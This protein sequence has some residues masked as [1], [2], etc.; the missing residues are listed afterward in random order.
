MNNKRWLLI[1]SAI[2]LIILT[3]CTS[4]EKQMAVETVDAVSQ[5]TPEGDGWMITLTGVRSEDLYESDVDAWIEYNPDMLKELSYE[6]KGELRNYTAIPFSAIVAICDDGDGSMPYTFEQEVW[7]SGYEI[8]LVSADGYAATFVTSEIAS[9]VIYIALSQDEE[10]ISPMVIGEIDG[11]FWVKELVAIELSLAPVTLEENDFEFI[12][13]IGDEKSS[14]TLAELKDHPHY[15]EDTGEYKNSHDIIF[16]HVWGGVKLVDLIGDTIELTADQTVIIQS[17][18]GYEMVYSGEQL[19]DQSDGTWILAF[20]E[21]GDYMPEDPGY[22]RLVKVGP[23]NPQITGHVSAKM[24]KKVIIEDVVFKDFSLTLESAEGSEIL[25]RQ[26]IQSGVTT[27]K[28]VVGYY[29]KKNDT[30][31]DYMGLPLYELF[32]HYPGYKTVSIEAA[33]GFSVTL[34]ASDIEGNTDVI[35]AMYYGDGSELSQREQPLV[36]AW[37]RE[38]SLIPEGIKAVR[39]IHRMIIE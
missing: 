35:L 33:D 7:D 20:I 23:D 29:H 39:N 34:E 26:T 2:F 5:A 25:D 38:A 16:P 13:E 17:T 3:S 32:S 4:L 15:I 30:I 24:I 19:L 37:D 27:H 1:A 18:D 22:I 14:Y 12:L 31:I 36:L 28:S 6:K 10:E 21:D 11:Q 9:E 8:T